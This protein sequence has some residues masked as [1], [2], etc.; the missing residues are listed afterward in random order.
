VQ[1][2]ATVNS[3]GLGRPILFF[4]NDWAAENRTSSHHIARWLAQGHRLI[5]IE[6][7]GL[8]APKRSSRDFKKVGAKLL[9]FLRGPHAVQENLEVWTLLQLPLHRFRFVRW[10]NCLLMLGALRWLKWSR[11]TKN[12]VTWFM[13]PHLASII[14]KLGEDVAVYYCI[15]DYA[16]LPDINEDAVRQMDEEMTRRASLVFVASDTLLESKRKLNPNTYVSPHGVDLVHF[17]RALQ[18]Q[19]QTP[20]ELQDLNRPIIGFFGL[21]EQWIDL[22]L[23]DSLARQR[24]NWTF[25]LI[26]RVAVPREHLP[27]RANILFLGVRSYDLLPDYGRQFDA[28]IIPYRLTR[29][30]LHANPIKL[31]EYLAMGKPVVSVATPEISKYNDVVRVARSAEDFLTHLDAAVA[32]RTSPEEVQRRLDRVAPESWDSRLGRVLDVVRG[33][34]TGRQACAG[35]SISECP[36]FAGQD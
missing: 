5:Y 3:T 7:P 24:P 14:G 19:G 31:R 28:A 23:V 32:E 22:E 13:L 11:R 8:R 6:C 10:L 20:A 17:A 25:V 18:G 12:P 4:G 2:L 30:A 29:Q 35:V 27:Q 36:I 33:H 21:I 1:G 16:A 9:S 26:G 15:D 34:L